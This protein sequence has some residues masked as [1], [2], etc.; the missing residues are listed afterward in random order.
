MHRPAAGTSRQE[1]D[2][3]KQRTSTITND[4]IAVYARVSTED[5]AEAGTVQTQ[6]D[7]LR[8]YADLHGLS[9]AG[10]YVDDGISGTVELA[11]RPE[12]RRLLDDA[13][14]G[15]FGT[16][17]V[18]R[19]DRLARKLAVMLNAQTAIEAHGVA[20]KSATEPI[21]T[22]TPIGRFIFQLLGSFAEFD[23]ASI[24]QRTSDGRA[25]VARDGRYVGGVLP[26]GYQLDADGRLVPSTRV[27]PVL[28]ITEAEWITDLFQRIANGETTAIAETTRLTALGV[29]SPKR[30]GVAK[31]K[32]KPGAEPTSDKAGDRWH[33]TRTI[34]ILHNRV[35]LGEG[36]MDAVGGAVAWDVPPL[37]DLE[38]WE[39]AQTALTRNKHLSKVGGNRTYLLRGL[40]RCQNCGLSYVGAA[41]AHTR[42]DWDGRIYRCGGIYKVRRPDPSTRCH[43]RT[44]HAD[45]L[46]D[47]VWNGCREY[48]E[49]PDRYLHDAQQALR[50]RLERATSADE[51]R[52]ELLTKLAEQEA[53]RERVLRLARKGLVS[54]DEAEREL[55]EINREAATLRALIESLRSDAALTTAA[56]A[57]LSETAAALTM[58]REQ[59]RAADATND[60]TL[61]RGVIERLVRQIEITTEGS[62]RR[63]SATA[64][65]RYY[66]EPVRVEV[67]ETPIGR[68]GASFQPAW[69][70]RPGSSPARPT[71][72]TMPA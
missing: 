38:T 36:R 16:V 56:E 8:K 69:A 63:T 13:E 18:Y 60:L 28:G 41:S 50:E 53:E 51:Q 21:D 12:G 45:E 29:P 35:Y 14:T 57:H 46:E 26:I 65:I 9:I 17:I 4:A 25:R 34:K 11:E 52:R 10:E 72:S 58:L 37:V 33:A 31:K 32:P 71:R 49:H 67:A 44:I 27:M 62:G 3:Q 30:Y 55:D 2:M 15:R 19:V 23:R 43:G 66:Y 20:L 40:I 54:M 7:F 24:L 48:I 68:P 39:R 61:K 47:A 70:A 64:R 42:V 5:Q 6:L 59:A 22:S 1:R